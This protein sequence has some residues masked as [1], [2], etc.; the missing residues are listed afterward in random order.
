MY[1]LYTWGLHVSSARSFL[2]AVRFV[3][4]TPVHPRSIVRPTYPYP[5]SLLI[6]RS[7]RFTFTRFWTLQTCLTR[8]IVACLVRQA[9]FVARERIFVK[10]D[11]KRM[12]H[13]LMDEITSRGFTLDR[14][15]PSTN[16]TRLYDCISLLLIA[17]N[18][19]IES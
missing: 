16:C 14:T 7:I 11:S 8:S 4:V 3:G 18:L 6:E 19:I 5:L 12:V 2:I 15:R 10:N 17:P 9:L 1:V 13:V